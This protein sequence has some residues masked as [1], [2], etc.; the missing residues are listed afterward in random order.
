ML[1]SNNQITFFI[2]S[3][4]KKDLVNSKKGN[5]FARRMIQATKIIREI[6]INHQ[7]KHTKLM[8]Y[9]FWVLLILSSMITLLTLPDSTDE[10]VFQ[11]EPPLN[12]SGEN[13]IEL[14]MEPPHAVVEK[15]YY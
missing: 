8:G 15:S 9:F 13:P 4:V 10:R 6:K 12:D 11:T 7:L 2:H 3:E 5:N 1:I 14:D